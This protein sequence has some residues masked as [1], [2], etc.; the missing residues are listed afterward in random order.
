VP[1]PTLLAPIDRFFSRNETPFGLACLRIQLPIML[2]T[3]AGHRAL[4]IRELYTTDGAPTPLWTNFNTPDFLPIPSPT[5]GVALFVCYLLSLLTSSAGFFTRTSLLAA[6]V[7]NTYFGLLDS[8]STMTK[9]IV[10]ASHVLFLLS[11][12]NCGTLWSADAWLRRKRGGMPVIPQ[13]SPIWPRRLIQLF[14]GIVYLGAASTKMHTEGFFSGDQ[15]SYWMMTNTNFA[16]PVGEYL[17]LYPGLLVAMSYI[18]IFW[19]ITF[20]TCCWKGTARTICLS[21]GL[22]FHL[23]TALTLGLYL[24]P[25]IY[26]AIYFA[27]FDEEDYLALRAWLSQRWP[28]AFSGWQAFFVWPWRKLDAI[29]PNWFGPSQAAAAFA[30]FASLCAVTAVEVESRADVY[31][32]ARAAGSHELQPLPQE[33]VD[34]LLREDTSARASDVVSAF[35]MGSELF[36]ETL[37]DRRKSYRFGESAIIQCSLEPPHPDVWLE[38]EMHDADDHVVH[39]DGM[40]VPRERLRGFTKFHFDERFPAGSYA[41]V[42]KVDGREITRRDFTIEAAP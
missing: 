37:I 38:V 30:V 9:Y 10:I 35:D 14:I 16:N 13:A 39:H 33:T 12:S 15:I 20:L 25:A 40:I 32:Q 28:M 36:G 19:E 7:L 18:T 27:F 22:M 17:S 3:A 26:V 24:F 8:I 23:M 6:T 42:L 21:M 31:G 34:R 41:L 4:R 11:L 2:L 29:R 5:W 1:Q